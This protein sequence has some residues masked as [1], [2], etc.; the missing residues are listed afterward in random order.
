MFVWSSVEPSPGLLRWSRAI[1][2]DVCH[3]LFPSA[4]LWSLLDIMCMY[5]IQGITCLQSFSGCM[6]KKHLKCEVYTMNDLHKHA[7]ITVMQWTINII[8]PLILWKVRRCYMKCYCVKWSIN[9]FKWNV[10][11]LVVICEDFTCETKD[12]HL[13]CEGFTCEMRGSSSEMWKIWWWYVKIFHVKHE[14]FTSE[15]WRIYMWNERIFRWNVKN[16]SNVKDLHVKWEGFIYMWNVKDFQVKCVGFVQSEGTTPEMWRIFLRWN[17]KDYANW[18]YCIWNVK[19]VQMMWRLKFADNMW[20]IYMWNTKD[21]KVEFEASPTE[22]W[23][24]LK[25]FERFLPVR[26]VCGIHVVHV[27]GHSRGIVLIWKVKG[28]HNINIATSVM[29][30]KEKSMQ[31]AWITCCLMTTVH[32]P[33]RHSVYRCERILCHVI[34]ECDHPAAVHHMWTGC[35]EDCSLQLDS[36]LIQLLLWTPRHTFMLLLYPVIVKTMAWADL[37]VIYSWTW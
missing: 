24:S 36:R 6:W 1:S 21:Y 28:V 25:G 5:M 33:S 31:D 37:A 26:V 10:K 27:F 12:L 18:R 9:I 16:S 2:S 35:S 17:V 14:G 8:C 29:F 4:V 7:Q 23:G 11:D 34:Q 19:H 30:M 22:M 32:C 20:R 13:K 3:I 15:M